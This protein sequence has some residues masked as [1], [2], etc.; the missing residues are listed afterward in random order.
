MVLKRVRYIAWIILD[1]EEH[2]AM[3]DVGRFVCTDGSGRNFLSQK[4]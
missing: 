4:H 1:H 3:T 2:S